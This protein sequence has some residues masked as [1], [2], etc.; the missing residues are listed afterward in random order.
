MIYYIL[1]HLKSA[2]SKTLTVEGMN[3]PQ[4]FTNYLLDGYLIKNMNPKY[5]KNSKKLKNMKKKIND[6]KC[7]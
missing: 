3:K 1:S 6:K 4:T 7:V 5:I 2:L